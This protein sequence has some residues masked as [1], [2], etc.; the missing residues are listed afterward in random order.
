MSGTKASGRRCGVCRHEKRAEIDK[1]IVSGEAKRGIAAR[2]RTSA[3]AMERHAKHVGRAIV[4]AAAR[5]GERLEETLL[6]KVERLEAD[7]RRLGERAET[8]GDLRAALVAVDKLLDVIRLLHE[9]APAAA[10]ASGLTVR[11]V[12][13][14]NW[15]TLG[16][17]VVIETNERSSNITEENEQAAQT[18]ASAEKEIPNHVDSLRIPAPPDAEQV[19]GRKAA[20]G[21]AR[22]DRRP[23]GPSRF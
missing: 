12:T 6:S 21:A 19:P 17:S 14:D 7:A 3:D 10:A 8:E 1:A 5:K 9:L 20:R 13:V 15:K 23:L 22:N 2:Y 4:R 18:S 11:I 16:Q